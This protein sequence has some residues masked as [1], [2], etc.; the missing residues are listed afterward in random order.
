MWLAT[1][2]TWVVFAADILLL[3]FIRSASDVKVSLF[4]IVT[5]V[6]MAG[7]RRRVAAGI[8]EKNLDRKI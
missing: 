7:G 4:W 1:T 6:F 3:T 2:R 5:M 8:V